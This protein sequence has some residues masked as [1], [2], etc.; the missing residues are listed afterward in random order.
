MYRRSILLA[1]LAAASLAA[2][3]PRFSRGEFHGR[4]AYF[5]ENAK[6]RVAALRGA[7][8]LA[9]VR[10]KSE[11]PRV[12]VN[13]MRVP[14]FPTI[15]PWEYD[16]AR[17][18]AVYGGGT[19]KVLQSGYMGHLLN[20]PTFGPPSEAE[21]ANGLGNH[22]E[23]LTREWKLDRTAVDD[24][25]A[26]LWYSAHLPQTQYNVGRVLTLPADEQVLYIEEWAESLVDYDRP[27]M[28][29][30]HV[31]FGPPFV[32][33]GKT[34]LDMSAG[35]GEVR[36]G[37]EETNSLSAGPVVWPNGKA[38]DGKPAELRAMRPD[39]H[40]GTYVG[41][42]MDPARERAWFTM[43]HPDYRVLIGYVWRT[44]DFPFMGDW[45]ENGRNTQL[46][47]QGKVQARG[48]E[49]GTTPFGGPMRSVVAEGP[50]LGKPTVRWMPGRQR[51]TVRYIAFVAEIPEGYR[52]VDDVVAGPG[53]LT[54]VERQTG[55][56]M[57]LKS[58]KKW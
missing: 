49:L 52:G 15:E 38:S 28:W 31:T 47:W 9:E 20:F 16:P 34:T 26:I 14:H 3:S 2:Q 7:G 56:R 4:D 45:Q 44:A 1:A 19:N 37:G 30:Q 6:I 8:H 46:P 42:E 22:G 32:E 21:I 55:K 57:T 29:V 25:S 10:L 40:S 23:A 33:A 17:H 18:D 41:Y 27:A 36:P 54:V 12:A 39:A 48:M 50:F 53:E 5:L 11:D 58:A 13:P 35:R 24:T 43:F 51:Q